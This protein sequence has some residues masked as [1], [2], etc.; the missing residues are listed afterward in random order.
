MVGGD[1]FPYT[2]GVCNGGVNSGDDC[3]TSA[4]CSDEPCVTE[5]SA[6]GPVY[7]PHDIASLDTDLF[8][9]RGYFGAPLWDTPASTWL[10]IVDTAGNPIR[11]ARVRLYQKNQCTEVIDNT[12]EYD[13]VSDAFG[14]V[15]LPNRG[16]QLYYST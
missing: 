12:P 9:R 7:T 3:L 8:D 6:A 15:F 4:D 2:L 16:V 13:V 5:N 10:R 1:V 11:D 14:V